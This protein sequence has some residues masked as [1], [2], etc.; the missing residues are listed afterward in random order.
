MFGNDVF[1]AP[2]SFNGCSP[3]SMNFFAF[4]ELF[5]MIW[6]LDNCNARNRDPSVCGTPL[7]SNQDEGLQDES[8]NFKGTLMHLPRNV[9]LLLGIGVA[10]VLMLAACGSEETLGSTSLDELADSATDAAADDELADFATEDAPDGELAE[11]GSASENVAY[12][13]FLNGCESIDTDAIAEILGSDV[14]FELTTTPASPLREC[15]LLVGEAAVVY[16]YTFPSSFADDD[17]FMFNSRAASDYDKQ[18]VSYAK[19]A[20]TRLG[21]FD[22]RNAFAHYDS[23]EQYISARKVN[24]GSTESYSAV[25]EEEVMKI[26]EQISSDLITSPVESELCNTLDSDGL[27][28]SAY[29]YLDGVAC[30]AA[31]SD[32]SRFVVTVQNT[33]EANAWVQNRIDIYDSKIS[34]KYPYEPDSDSFDE[35]YI[36]SD[37][38]SNSLNPESDTF[39]ELFGSSG[40]ML[41]IASIFGPAAEQDTDGR[42]V[43]LA[44]KALSQ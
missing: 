13:D 35:A 29:N 17:V 19:D 14:T 9:T 32:G 5:A 26:L 23:Y 39:D 21:S 30:F 15:T 24:P 4:P 16:S 28:F 31:D 38:D 25:S 7:G 33:P 27:S 41:V 43:E 20:G 37:K 40:D 18:S 22:F 36:A 8:T 11:S 3:T 34:F 42:L 2:V 12:G 1:T 44:E 6:H 10:V